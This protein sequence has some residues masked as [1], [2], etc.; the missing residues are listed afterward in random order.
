VLFLDELPELG[1]RN[2]ETLRQPLEDR[3]ITI[4]RASGSLTFPANFVL[5]A[6]MNPC[7]C[8]HFGSTSTKCQC[9]PT[10]AERYQQR[11]SGPLL[12]RFDLRVELPPVPWSEITRS[13]DS[14][15]TAEVRVRV[16]AA[17]AQQFDRQSR[18]NSEL[19]GPLLRR[20]CYPVDH[21]GMTLIGRAVSRMG[22][23]ARGVSRVL[24]VARTI[25][26]LEGLSTVTSR[27]VAEAL[28]FRVPGLERAGQT[29]YEIGDIGTRVW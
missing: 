16:A 5:V 1:S 3:V 21:A 14:E 23:S 24:R 13:E 12:D 22:L 29:D 28:H 7:P 9:G 6:A 27:H 8:G 10:V 11:T 15:T 25:A 20:H 4:S 2:L 17:R 26:D 18:L 19:D